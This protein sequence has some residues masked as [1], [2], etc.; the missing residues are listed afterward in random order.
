LRRSTQAAK[1][2]KMNKATAQR[3]KLSVTGGTKS[4]TKRPMTALLAHSK[5]GT[6]NNKAVRG[7]SFWDMQHCIGMRV[8]PLSPSCPTTALV[9]GSGS[10]FVAKSP[11]S[12]HHSNRRTP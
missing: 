3:K 9:F 11:V 5:G 8:F 6:V 1:G 2:S 7:D 10:R 12:K 4:L